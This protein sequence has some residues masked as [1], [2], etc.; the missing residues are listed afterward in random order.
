[1]LKKNDRL[2][3]TCTDYTYLGLGVVKHEGFCLFVKEM[4]V[5]E[6]GEIVVTAI[7]KDYGYGR[8]LKKN[9]LSGARVD[10]P[11]PYYPQCGG[12]QL[13]HMSYPEQLKLKEQVIQ[14]LM[15]GISHAAE[16][17]RPIIAQ[18]DP[19]HYRNKV[20]I[21][22]QTIA[23]QVSGGF[24]RYNSHEI[25]PME[26]CILQ[27]ELSNQLYRRTLELLNKHQVLNLVRHILIKHAFATDQVMIV[28]IVKQDHLPDE[29]A[30]IQDLSQNEHVK[31]II[32]NLNQRD[33]NVILG[34]NERV[35]YGSDHI[36]DVLL[37][38]R[39]N[40]SSKSFYQI[41][42][43][44]TAKLYQKAYELAELKH[45]DT[46]LDLY[47]GIGTIG[48][49]ASRDVKQVIGIEAVKEA[50]EDAIQNAK[51]NQADNIEFLTGD[52]GQL[53]EQLLNEGYRFDTVFIDPPRKGC[54]QQTIETLI[55]LN[56]PKII[57]ISCNPATLA[58]D[59]AKFTEQG[60]N[61][62]V[63]QPVDMFPQTYHVECVVELRK[64]D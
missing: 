2:I 35:V 26:Y 39:F 55:R 19:F 40:I 38:Y 56:S 22:T 36:E 7:Q 57:Y 5:G 9:Q 34:K 11:C 63:I 46:I 50:V 10:A 3:G 48:L 29:K 47:C 18:E 45:D 42:S 24:Y 28:L 30:L 27:S 14:R 16:L 37:G 1:M 25:I 31:S 8:L 53:T 62:K 52:A 51:L 33:D 64:K 58:R 43:V 32:I 15:S 44:Q 17:I 12:C 59:L 49:I 20:Q 21:P 4:L 41:N 60:Y 6:S 13:Q 54:D 23:G 61:V